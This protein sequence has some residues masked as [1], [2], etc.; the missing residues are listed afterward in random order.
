MK[1]NKNISLLELKINVQCF[2]SA[3]ALILSG[4]RRRIPNVHEPIILNTTSTNYTAIAGETAVLYCA[5]ANLGTKTV[6]Q[7][8][9]A[10][11][12]PSS[13][14][15][16]GVIFSI[17]TN[18]YRWIIIVSLNEIRLKWTKWDSNTS[19]FS[20]LLIN[21]WW[22]LISNNNNENSAQYLIDIFNLN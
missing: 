11:P 12:S 17:I 4:Y 6:R 10:P 19:W 7:H 2:H 15:I 21:F 5:V 14:T 16:H 8:Y 3:V 1:C 13:L 9:K 18:T 20:P 22:C